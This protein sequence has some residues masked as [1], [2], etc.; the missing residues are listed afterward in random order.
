MTCSLL[1][2]TACS[3]DPGSDAGNGDQ[4]ELAANARATAVNVQL[5]DL[6]EGYVAIPPDDA[7]GDNAMLDGCVE[8]LGEVTVADAESPTF[9]RQSGGGVHFVASETSVLSDPEPAERLLDSVT[10]QAVLDCLSGDLGEVLSSI[11]PG[12]TTEATLTLTPDPAL[13]DV[14]DE[15]VHLTGTATFT[16]PGEGSISISAS[17]TFLQTDEVLSVL[18]FGGIREPFPPETLRSVAGS[19]AERQ[20]AERQS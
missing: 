20:S 12:A 9:R 11:L 13:P 16:Q 8:D 19:V 1:S 2:V 7:E 5:T 15:R 18:L 17:L 14:G 6:P 4:G 3:D 10:D